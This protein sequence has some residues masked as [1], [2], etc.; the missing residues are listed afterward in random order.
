MSQKFSKMQINVEKGCNFV[1]KLLCICGCVYQLQ[2][3]VLT[4]FSFETVTQN[5]FIDPVTVQFPSLHYCFMTI[6]DSMNRSFIKQKYGLDTATH[7]HSEL[8]TDNIT[9]SEILEMS[10]ETVM[11]KCLF[12]DSTG[13]EV[14][15]FVPANECN[16]FFE[17]KK[18]VSQQYTCY[19]L[20]PKEKTTM[21]FRS[22]ESSLRYERVIYSIYFTGLLASF[23]KIRFTLTGSGFPF[24]S[25]SYSPSFYKTSVERISAHLFCQNFTITTLGY[26]YDPF[27]CEKYE[28]E[29]FNCIDTCLMN[30]TYNYFG[31]VPFTLFY[32]KPLNKKLLSVPM[33]QNRTASLALN[34][35]YD[36]CKKSCPTFPCQYDFCITMGHAN[37]ARNEEP[38]KRII[39]SA[40]RVESPG[41]PN[42]F[43]NYIPKLPLLDF[44]IYVMSSLGTW[45]GL[46]IISCNPVGFIK[47][48]IT[49]TSSVVERRLIQRNRPKNI[50]IHHFERTGIDSM[51][52][53]LNRRRLR[54]INRR[55]R[56]IQSRSNIH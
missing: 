8:L 14:R 23:R 3:V 30:R 44:I 25:R 15:E 51:Q 34:R 21:T 40:I 45:F 22:I 31:R 18:Y 9:I 7:L 4:Y 20:I 17:T 38:E 32:D 2:N 41:Q 50:I 53:F 19:Q 1:Y 46:V 24:V 28:M 16:S 47:Q 10:P 33:I 6:S 52:V 26:P 27:T 43:I 5:R 35:I 11:D 37:I 42:A 29:H 36:T 54:P 56:R 49:S 12:R 48:M 55:R 39:G 13:N